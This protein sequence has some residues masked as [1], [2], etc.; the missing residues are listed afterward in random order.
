MKGT[1]HHGGTEAR[2]AI[3]PS[4]RVSVVSSLLLL[5][6]WVDPVGAQSR[7][8]PEDR[9]VL[10]SMLEI[11]A[12]ASSFERLYVVAGDQ[13]LIRD[14]L[15]RRW[16]G[17]F[18]APGRAALMNAQ[19]ALVDPFDRS[20]WVVTTS[21]WLRYDPVLD[22][23]DQGFAVANILAAGIDRTRPTDGLYLRT[24]DGWSVAARGSG[25]LLPATRPPRPTDLVPV[26]TVGAAARA[27]PQLAG[28][29]GGM[30]MGPGLRPARLTAAAESADRSGWWLGTDGAGLFF[31]PF[32][33]ARPEPRPW[34]LPGE[35]VGA[36]FAVPGGA[37]AV[38][39]RGLG[40]G[41]AVVYVPDQIEGTNWFFGDQVMGQPFRT[42]RALLPAD[43]LLWI[44]TDQGALALT[45]RGERV[46]QLTEGNGLPDR[47][48]LSIAARRGRLVFGTAAGIAELTDSGVVR[49]APFYAAPAFALALSGDTTWVGTPNGLFAATP[50]EGDLRQA[51]GWETLPQRTV[52]TALR[53]RG[54]TLVALTD[55]ALLYRDPRDGRWSMGPDPGTQVG[56][57]RALADGGRGVWIAGS[58][59]VGFARLG[60]A[61]ERLLA[62]GPD[63]PGE[64]WDVSID[65]GWLWIATS[66]GLVRF[67]REAVEP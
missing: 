20:L 50:G 9:V 6:C 64:A 8:R 58:R 49:L 63:L 37:W 28:A 56:R 46:H 44:G 66:R 16:T 4:L 18:R 61:V 43:T 54:D 62:V 1:P 11:D 13:L 51:P 5:L 17:P 39:D 67:R 3:S 60:G 32:G 59:G 25:A 14:E 35:V 7:W 12:I 47:R 27:N 65:G 24:P 19:G 48:V 10:G 53:W 23:W 21:G 45:R 33:S 22:L 40:T 29:A 38:T 34:G 15:T 41:A 36:V 2:R 26:G 52:V 31:L 57:A 30:L 55:R 42:V